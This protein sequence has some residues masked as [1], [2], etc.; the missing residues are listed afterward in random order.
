MNPSLLK[1]ALAIMLA[2]LS[3]LNITPFTVDTVS[4]WLVG[5]GFRNALPADKVDM[6]LDLYVN[7]GFIF[8]SDDA[9]RFA[10]T[11]IGEILIEVICSEGDGE[12]IIKACNELP[13]YDRNGRDT[14]RE[15]CE[16][17]TDTDTNKKLKVSLQKL[18]GLSNLDQSVKD[19]FR[20]FAEGI[21]DIYIYFITTDYEGV[22]EF[23]GDFV[24]DDGTQTYVGYTGVYYDST[25]T[26]FYGYNSGG[27]LQIG[28]DFTAK[29]ITMSNPVNAWQRRYGY[30]IFFDILGNVLIIDT[31]TVRVRFKYNGENKM[32]QFWKGNYTRIANGAEIGLYNRQ[33][34]SLI[35][36]DSVPDEEMLYMSLKLYHGDELVLQN[37]RKLHW[38]LTGYQPGPSVN[39]SEL[40]LESSIEFTDE[41]MLSAFFEAAVDAFPKDATV[42]CDGLTAHIIW[43]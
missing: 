16:F 17:E 6:L 9:E 23:A 36:Y 33:K 12:R 38:W 5:S 7:Q 31:D 2:L 22:Y 25:T 29:S 11:V 37:D 15:G 19:G 30:N 32:F 4:A 35:C 26:M 28:F 39:P 43:N 13:I 14:S 27:M 21:N 41:A 1:K 8:L 20:V 3:V 24:S 40:T 10:R 18:I 42:E 34:D